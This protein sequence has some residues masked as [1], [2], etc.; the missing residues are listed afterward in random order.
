MYLFL[1]L[2]FLIVCFLYSPFIKPL[3]PAAATPVEMF[4][5]TA[6]SMPQEWGQ[7]TGSYDF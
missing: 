2:F 5:A 4:K 1:I 6:P 7:A 3:S